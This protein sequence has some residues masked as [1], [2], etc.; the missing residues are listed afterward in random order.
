M[1]KTE[2]RAT[3]HEGGSWIRNAEEFI[4]N[5]TA[6]QRVYRAYLLEAI[7]E[8]NVRINKV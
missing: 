1:G 5:R 8:I 6:E 4:A 2:I 7:A 3:L